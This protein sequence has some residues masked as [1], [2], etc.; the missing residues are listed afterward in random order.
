MKKY[1]VFI[2]SRIPEEGINLLQKQGYSLKFGS[3]KEAKGAHAV[4]CLLTDTVDAKVMDRIGPQL[5]VVSNM[6]AGLDN[7]DVH[8]AV[9]RGITFTNTPGVLTEAVAEHTVALLLAVSRRVVEGDRFVRAKKYK[10]WQVD[11]LLGQELQGKTLGIVGYGRIGSRVAAILDKGFGM[12]VVYHDEHR[13]EIAEKNN[14]RYASF[15]NLLKQS[16][17]VSLHV[18][19]LATTAHLLDEKALRMMKRTSYLINTSRG[20]VVDEKALGKALKENTIAGAGIDVF[21]HEPKV[22][23]SLLKAQN[24]VLTPHIASASHE[25]RVAMA[26]LAAKNIIAVLENL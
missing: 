23:S 25:A 8:E 22:D 9:K 19:L 18:P 5:K 21:E 26:E 17:V 2:T 12:N 1:T 10:G 6:A 4:L 15:E 24:A 11:L 20:A 16:D 14:A 7:I 13:N 3:L